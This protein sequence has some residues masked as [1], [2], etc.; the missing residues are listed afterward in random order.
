MNSAA[1]CLRINSA[2]A[3]HPH[4]RLLLTYS[5]SRQAQEFGAYGARQPWPVQEIRVIEMIKNTDTAPQFDGTAADSAKPER[6][7]G[8]TAG[9]HRAVDQPSPVL[10]PK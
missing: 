6:Q 1:G 9:F 2:R 3:K 7:L 10:P 8:K 5:S 4:H